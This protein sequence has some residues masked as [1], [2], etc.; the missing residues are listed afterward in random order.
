MQH[1]PSLQRKN[2]RKLH[3]L[4]LESVYVKQKVMEVIQMRMMDPKETG[5]K[6]NLKKLQIA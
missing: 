4:Q 3:L 2:P 5:D 1:Q 6:L